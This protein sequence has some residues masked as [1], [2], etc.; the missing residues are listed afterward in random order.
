[1]VVAG[2]NGAGKSSIVGG[3]LPQSGSDYFNP[4]AFAARLVGIGKP[5][6]EANAVAWRLGYDRLR[7]A[8]DRGD[9]FT[10]ETTLGGDSIVAELHRALKLRRDVR[11]FYLGLSS[12]ELHIARVRARVARGGHD[13]PPSKIRE[14]YSRSLANLVTLIGKASTIQVFD[15]SIETMDGVPNATL[16][17]R[18]RGRK[19]VEP[20]RVRLL[21]TCPEWAKPIVAAAIRAGRAGW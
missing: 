12:V 11:V 15:N 10:F 13:I 6:A 3:F 14:R 1:M 7:T 20:S 17:F 16:I 8:I 4:D 18:M 2:T 21:T 5:L 19:I 9:R